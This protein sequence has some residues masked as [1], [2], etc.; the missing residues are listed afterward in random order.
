MKSSTLGLVGALTLLAGGEARAMTPPPDTHPGAERV[1]VMCTVTAQGL[2]SDCRFDWGMKEDAK[3]LKAGS[4][5]G[6]LDAH[7][8][9]I[10]GAAPGAEVKVCVRLLLTPAPGGKGYYV[11]GA[12]AP[13]PS[14]PPI[15]D[16]VWVQ[17]PHDSWIDGFVPELAVRF[18]Q[19]GSAT[20]S[21]T[22]TADGALANCWVREDTRPD[23]GFGIAGMLALQHARMAPTT[24]SGA[25][26]AGRTYVQTFVF[27]GGTRYERN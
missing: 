13:A 27:D 18:A 21:C 20:V 2:S 9:P 4:E 19:H 17:S 25:P 3:R 14:G 11:T 26:V 22:A 12:S 6:Y 24:A 23:L 16:P 5:L 1:V 10:A 8:I 15:E 7:P